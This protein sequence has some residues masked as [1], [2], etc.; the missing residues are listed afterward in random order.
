MYRGTLASIAVAVCLS[1]APAKGVAAEGSDKAALARQLQGMSY[2]KQTYQKM[3]DGMSSQLPEDAR[4]DFA[5][6][7]PSYQELSDFQMGLFMKYYT[8]SDLRALVK[9]YT[10]PTGKKSLEVMPEVMQ[11]VQAM[12]MSRLQSEMPKLMEKMKQKHPE[13]MAPGQVPP[14]KSGA[15][16]DAPVR[17]P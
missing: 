1:L 17:N 13:G 15:P 7:L 2:S 5:A 4:A 16:A 14:Q 6:I 10:S 3:V 12:V 8:E 9:F 11:D